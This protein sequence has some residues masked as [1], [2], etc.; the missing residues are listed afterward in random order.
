[1]DRDEELRDFYTSRV[2]IGARRC[3]KTQQMAE[4]RDQ[5]LAAGRPV[6]LASAKPEGGIHVCIVKPFKRR[7]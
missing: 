5:A 4:E 6:I 7:K 2:E 3:G 1:M